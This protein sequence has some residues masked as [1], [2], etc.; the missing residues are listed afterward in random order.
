[1]TLS[2]IDLQ[3]FRQKTDPIA[4]KVIEDI[5]A[6]SGVESI[7]ELFSQLRD[8]TDIPQSN[9]HESVKIYFEQTKTLP[10]WIDQAKIKVG[11][12]VFA[13]HGPQIS[14]SLLC[15][16]L[17]EAY[18]CANGAKVLYAT[19]RMTERNGS[20]EVFTRRLM[21]TAQFV[22]NVCTPGGLD[23]KG[24]GIITAQK[25]RLIHA[26]IRFY[27]KRHEW[28]TAQ[29]GEPINQQ[30]MAGTLQSFSTLIIEGLEKMKL[31]LTEEQKEGYYHCWRVIG[32]IMGVEDELN[33]PTYSEGY[34]LGQT[35]LKSQ[36]A[37]SKEG[38]ILTRAVCDFMS[39]MLPGKIFKDMPEIII[40]FL[41]GDKV[42]NDL[43]LEDHKTLKSRL[44]P[45]L[46]DS[47]FLTIDEVENS[48]HF[49]KKLIEHMNL[50]L[51]Q[52]MLT[53]FNENKK[54]RFYIPPNLREDW[55]L[56]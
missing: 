9:L 27:I 51:L 15:K 39:D 14:L 29:Y 33:P 42:A 36:I 2:N 38:A 54:V 28:P 55:K 19:G 34:A 52:S 1:M 50:F 47:V 13:E 17:P 4:D 44:V 26:A 56:K 30:D 18:A 7:N 23:P 46:L 48:S 40:R 6:S 24:N 22:V 11:Q 35:I 37:P 3:K 43:D 8:N 10:D 41:V 45:K 53:H 32:F 21:E 20:L 16:S 12:A 5:I 25:V 31:D 49:M